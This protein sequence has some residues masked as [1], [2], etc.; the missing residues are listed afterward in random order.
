[1]DYKV[2]LMIAIVG[3][4]QNM[5]F[6][7]S[8]RSRNGGDPKYH[9]FVAMGSNGIWFV[10]NFFLIL[11]EMLKVVESG[12]LLMKVV[13]MGDYILFTSLGSAFMMQWAKRFEK[14]KRKVGA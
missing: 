8:S 6:T 2:L 11:P 3:F 9:F 5:A 13:V 7:W 12:D 4:I 14:G 10:M 1:M